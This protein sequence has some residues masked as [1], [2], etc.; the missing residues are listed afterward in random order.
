MKIAVLT[1][2]LNSNYG[3]ILQTYALQTVLE[4]LGHHVTVFDHFQIPQQQPLWR[5]PFAFIRRTLLKYIFRKQLRVFQER[6]E[7]KVRP[8]ILR[9]M[10]DFMERHLHRV[11]PKHYCDLRKDWSYDAVIVGSDQ[12]WRKEYFP[13]RIENAFLGFVKDKQVQRI[14]YA[15]SFGLD[16]LD[17]TQK[18]IINCGK[19]LRMFDAVSVRETSGIKIC[20][21][22]LGVEAQQVLDPTLLLK[23]EDYVQLIEEKMPTKSGGTLMVSILDL[24]DK[25]QKMVDEMAK[26]RGLIPFQAVRDSIYAY[27]APLN[28]R[29]MPSVESWLQGFRDAELVITDSFHACVFSIIFHKPFIAL[30]NKARGMSRFVSLL[31]LFGLEDRLTKMDGNFDFNTSIDWDDVDNRL[32]KLRTKSLAF[33]QEHLPC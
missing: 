21:D 6:Y 4:R 28:K 2:P 25:K 18:E 27:D 5:K 11:M 1:L 10:L 26:Q 23:K 17:F 12:V 24:T 8:L 13:E 15:A 7:K 30:G 20:K 32:D 14:S 9:N 31:S 16:V 29:I 19:L 33:L 22:R 3:G